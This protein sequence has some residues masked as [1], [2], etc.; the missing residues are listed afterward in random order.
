MNRI[1]S[2][3]PAECTPVR[4][5][6][7]IDDEKPIRMLTRRFLEGEGFNILDASDGASGVEL[8]TA[9]APDLHCVL[10]DMIM[11]GMNGEEA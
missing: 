5:I 11:P 1:R 4:T 6:L 2:V 9:H 10:L 8:C 3:E 7:L